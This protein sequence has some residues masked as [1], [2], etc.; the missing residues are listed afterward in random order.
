MLCFQAPVPLPHPSCPFLISLN[1]SCRC[2]LDPPSFLRNHWN[3]RPLFLPSHLPSFSSPISPDELA[4]LALS[5]DFPSRLIKGPPSGPFTIKSGPFQSSD[6]STLP[7][8]NWTLL[9]N[10][11]QRYIG[12]LALLQDAFSF[13]P[14][15]RFDDVMISYAA[16]GGGVGPHLDNYDVFLVQ[17]SGRR[18]WS[19]GK[20]PV[21]EEEEQWEE[22]SDVRVLKGGFQVGEEWEVKPGDVLYV[23]PRWPHW[24]VALDSDCM[25]YSVG[26]RAPN[27]GQLVMGWVEEIC[28][29]GAFYE[30]DVE[31]L[32]TNLGDAGLISDSA[33]ENAWEMVKEGLVGA[34][35]KEKFSK[36]FAREVSMPKRFRDEE[37]VQE[38]LTN[39]EAKRV[40]DLLVTRKED[41]NV[42]QREGSI[43]T[44]RDGV[45]GTFMFIDGTEW[46][47]PGIE[48]AK[49]LCASRKLDTHKLSSVI[50]GRPDAC[51]LITRL[52][53]ADLLYVLEE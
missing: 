7:S 35:A 18:R 37:D 47:V 30:D 51:D 45:D 4:G 53:E 40:V 12:S 25:T 20:G 43:F 48:V 28:K 11:A 21:S 36:W 49:V 9:V 1:K 27:E 29:E 41:V 13:I 26:F 10:D 8:S 2:S 15:W 31:D 5:P 3:R 6:L 50:H 42:Y 16:V 14:S 46:A 44:Y 32:V 52:F 19:V 23:P 17:G 24:G 34:H 33:V 38:R 39:D 22:N